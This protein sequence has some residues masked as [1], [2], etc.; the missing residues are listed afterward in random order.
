MEEHLSEKVGTSDLGDRQNILP[1]CLVWFA[2][3]PAS[4]PATVSLELVGVEGKAVLSLLWRGDSGGG[5]I[6]RPLEQ[7]SH[8]VISNT[9]VVSGLI[10]I[11]RFP[12]QGSLEKELT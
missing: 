9:V 6:A 1:V 4:H 11:D 12:V 7:P 5:E 3:C 2:P 8:K 10:G